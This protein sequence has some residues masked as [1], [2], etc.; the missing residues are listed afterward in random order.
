MKK[1]G[2]STRYQRLLTAMGKGQRVKF[3]IDQAA[4]PE[5]EP[6]PTLP[7]NDEMYCRRL[8]CWETTYG[9]EH[10]CRAHL[11]WTLCQRSC[12][13]CNGNGFAVYGQW[14]H[15][16]PRI[17]IDAARARQTRA[18]D[19]QESVTPGL[20]NWAMTRMP[21]MYH[22]QKQM[23]D[24]HWRKHMDELAIFIATI[25]VW[26]L[27]ILCEEGANPDELTY[28]EPKRV[29]DTIQRIITSCP[30]SEIE[31]TTSTMDDTH[32]MRFAQLY[33]CQHPCLDPSDPQYAANTFL[34]NELSRRRLGMLYESPFVYARTCPCASRI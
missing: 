30:P 12:R 6:A 25:E 3:V 7:P 5:P 4:E 21:N 26:L 9:Q 13:Y 14:A 8:E 10:Y 31:E 28:P 33:M 18:Y 19:A 2:H 17:C 1:R 23:H 11:P 29:I 20:Q 34:A 24:G 27:D 22:P 15:N 16:G 32:F